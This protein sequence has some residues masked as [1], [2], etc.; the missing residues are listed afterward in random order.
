MNA[1]RVKEQ[2]AK[3][4][5]L[6][7]PTCSVAVLELKGSPHASA[8]CPAA[9]IDGPADRSHII[10]HRTGLHRSNKR[11][12]IPLEESIPF[13]LFRDFHLDRASARGVLNINEC[14]MAIVTGEHPYTIEASTEARLADVGR[15]HPASNLRTFRHD[16]AADRGTKQTVP[17][18][19]GT[20]KD[21]DTDNNQGDPDIQT[22]RFP[23]ACRPTIEIHVLTSPAKRTLPCW[24]NRFPSSLFR[25]VSHSPSCGHA[26]VKT[27]FSV[28]S[29]TYWNPAVP[30]R[31]TF[32]GKG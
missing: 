15:E 8:L 19:V 17:E 27:E 20:D 13:V 29:S 1:W 26:L 14:Q 2:R 5:P 11:L 9:E 16:G 6:C 28:G 22:R 24:L 18:Q 21:A 3:P 23:A 12:T 7:W 30:H 4:N 25:A 32:D 31:A 10:D